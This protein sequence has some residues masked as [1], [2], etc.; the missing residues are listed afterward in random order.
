VA[1]DSPAAEAGLKVGDIITKLGGKLVED[2]S[3][4]VELV[5]DASPGDKLT[6]EVIRDGVEMGMLIKVGTRRDR[7]RSS[8][9]R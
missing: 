7:G 2:Y 8:R 9:N 4:F 3:A 6:M 1:D 5:T